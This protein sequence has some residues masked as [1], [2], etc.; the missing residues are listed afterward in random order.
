MK[1]TGNPDGRDIK[2]KNGK[3]EQDSGIASRV[4]AQMSGRASAFS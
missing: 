1:K 3:I 2:E 4:A